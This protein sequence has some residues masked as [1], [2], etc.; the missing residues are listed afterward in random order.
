MNVGNYDYLG[1]PVA[2]TSLHEEIAI[3]AQYTAAVY[4]L[5]ALFYLVTPRTEQP[6]QLANLLMWLVINPIIV[7]LA[8]NTM[9]QQLFQGTESRTLEASH[10][11]VA[12][13]PSLKSQ[14][15][16]LTHGRRRQRVR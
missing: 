11:L 14:I 8:L 16:V 13:C 6:L 3:C 4:T 10:L 5:Q 15:E 1:F 2:G 9:A 7:G 12:F